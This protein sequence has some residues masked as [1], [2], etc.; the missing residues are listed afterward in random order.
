MS[1]ISVLGPIMMDLRGTHLSALE[2]EQLRHP[3]VGGVILFTRNFESVSQLEALI[4]EIRN[5]RPNLLIAADTE[6]GR[7]Q[8]FRDGFVQH[9]PA[10]EYGKL[11]R[12]DPGLAQR[13][14]QAGGF[15][16]AAELRAVDID[17]AFAPVL[18]IDGGVSSVIGDR[19]FSDDVHAL[20]QLAHAFIQ[21]M[22]AAGMSSTGKHFPGHGFV[23]PDSHLELP[24]DE[25]NPAALWALDMQPYRDLGLQQ[26]DSVMVAHVRY[27]Q[28]DELPA[29]ISE[30]WITQELR[31][32]LRY[33]GAVFSDDL[34]MGGLAGFGDVL[35]RCQRALQAGCDMLPVCN[36][37]D[38]LA[39]IFQQPA[40]MLDQKARLRLAALR[41]DRQWHD[42]EELHC[43]VTYTTN[44]NVLNETFKVETE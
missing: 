40:M 30:R 4:A 42:L 10:A 13:A 20:I 43:D 14:A 18:D 11:W 32:N 5:Q 31:Q 41:R 39:A 29:S 34:S 37:P 33:E 16:L 21:G 27:A 35:Q 2:A 23:V 3:S 22:H 1:D 25:R 15:V 26:L 19:A 8:R 24:D 36:R 6:G 28:I 17:L 38:D 44:I 7:V 12:Q 9:P